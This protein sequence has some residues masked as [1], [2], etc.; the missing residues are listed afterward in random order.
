MNKLKSKTCR[1]NLNKSRILKLNMK[2]IEII[3]ILCTLASLINFFNCPGK[4]LALH[5]HFFFSSILL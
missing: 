3:N 5:N 4:F 2:E 1:N